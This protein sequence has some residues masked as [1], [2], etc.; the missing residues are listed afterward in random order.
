[1]SNGL[2]TR[3]AGVCLIAATALGSGTMPALASDAADIVRAGAERMLAALKAGVS[4][5]E[6]TATLAEIMASSF[7][8]PA[9]ARTV[10]GRH[11]NEA[12]AAQRQRFVAVFEKAE[13][14]A[15]SARFKQYSGQT[16]QVGKVMANGGSQMVESRIVQASATQPIRLTWEVRNAKII[17]VIIEGVSMA[18]TRRSDFNAYIQRHGIDGL[19]AELE[20]RS[21]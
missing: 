2:L 21:A 10:L 3:R 13:V 14:N 6:R 9:I 20:R 8:L 17:D 19:I 1:M 15:Y 7:D 11:W 12:T 16:L 4:D 18:A 5:A